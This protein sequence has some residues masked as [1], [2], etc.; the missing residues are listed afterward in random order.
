M[1]NLELEN[2]IQ[3]LKNRLRSVED[4]LRRVKEIAEDALK[5]AKRA[6]K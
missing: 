3:Q 2:E 5:R 1:T 6:S 4:E